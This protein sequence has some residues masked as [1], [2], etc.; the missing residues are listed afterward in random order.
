MA[1][2]NHAAAWRHLVHGLQPDVALLQE[3]V[4][5]PVTPPAQV[6]HGRAYTAQSWGSA[7]YIREGTMSELPLPAEHQGW[8]IAAEILL[9][10]ADPLVVVSVHAR[11]L[12]RK[13]RPNLDR[14]F[15]AIE[16]LLAG[17]SFV[18]GGDL[19][20]S[21]N[22]DTAYGTKHHAEFLDGLAARG[23]FECMRKF[24]V[25]EQRTFWGRTSRSYQNDHLFVSDDLADR[26]SACEVSD[27][28]GLSDHS[29][30][31]LHL[32]STFERT[33]S[34]QVMPTAEADAL[35][36]EAFGL[37]RVRS[38]RPATDETS[39]CSNGHPLTYSAVVDAYVC[40]QGAL[41]NNT[42]VVLRECSPRC[43]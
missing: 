23:F 39:R 31:T 10:N 21:R 11:I 22:Y 28:A 25:E 19:N 14:A 5:P 30:L 2:R 17:R 15:E 18:L 27:H 1:R 8:V 32:D 35:M 41:V 43:G 4:P 40:P 42:G 7:V 33:T 24:H 37:D 36:R 12:D 16:E 29:P 38:D 6:T 20:L 3:T 26:V 9:P 34:R 13:V